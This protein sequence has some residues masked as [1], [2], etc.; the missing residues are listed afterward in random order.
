MSHVTAILGSSVHVS[1]TEPE[2]DQKLVGFALRREHTG[3]LEISFD[4]TTELARVLAALRD[5]G[6]AFLG[7]THG[8]P[9]AEVFADL[10]DKGL[11]SGAFDEIVFAGPDA[12]RTRSR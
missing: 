8:W 5:L 12:M 11:V 2:L 6:I 10:R 9:P 1:G 3:Q 7:S 4:D